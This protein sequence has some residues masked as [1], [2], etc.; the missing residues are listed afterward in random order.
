MC[1]FTKFQ[2]L[3]ELVEEEIDKTGLNM[4][5]SKFNRSLTLF[6]C[7]SHIHCM[8]SKET[9][10]EVP[11]ELFGVNAGFISFVDLMGNDLQYIPD[12]MFESLPNLVDLKLGHNFIHELPGKG[13]PRGCISKNV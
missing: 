11:E 5:T 2:N 1:D 13:F 7:S 9:L 10:E 6:M 12:E 4:V 3:R 8:K